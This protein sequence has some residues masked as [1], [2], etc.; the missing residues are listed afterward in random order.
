MENWKGLCNVTVC[1]GRVPLGPG[2]DQP[3]PGER[4]RTWRA[5]LGKGGVLNNEQGT[6]K[7]R[8]GKL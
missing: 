8:K 4:S 5:E 2:D 7:Q 1:T 3:G 6:A